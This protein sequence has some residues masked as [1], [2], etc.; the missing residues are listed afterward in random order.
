MLLSFCR[1]IDTVNEWVGKTSQ[2]LVIPLTLIVT[3]EVILR[4]VFERPTLWAWDVNIMLL[5]ALGVLSGGYILLHKGH[6]RVDVLVVRL[7]S[8][9]RAII[10][11]FTVPF[12]LLA[13]GILLWQWVPEAWH[14]IQTREKFTSVF[15]PPIYPLKIVIVSGILLLLLQGVADIVRNIIT[16]ASPKGGDE[17]KTGDSQ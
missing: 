12:F 6:V 14:S 2:W 9:K 10:E 16:L 11:L 7:S 5:G 3:L 4:Y 17:S 8:R 15:M 13:I 1:V